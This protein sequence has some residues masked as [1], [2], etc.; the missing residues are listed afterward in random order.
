MSLFSSLRPLFISS[1][2]GPNQ[3]LQNWRERIL[4]AIATIGAISGLAV[5][6]ITVSTQFQRG[7]WLLIVIYS[8]AYLWMISIAIIR[9][10]PYII[11]ASSLILLVFLIGLTTTIDNATVGD[12]NV[13][14]VITPIFAAIF[15][16]GR[17]GF[18]TAVV[19]FGTWLLLG[20][21]F[22][23]GILEYPQKS[24]EEMVQPEN[25]G[26]WI[27]TGVT[28]FVVSLSVAAS[29]SAV[30]NNLNLTLQRSQE[31]TDDIEENRAQLQE[32]TNLL[33][34]RTSAL[35]NTTW[36]VSD[37][38]S[39]LKPDKLLQR[40]ALLIQ[41]T[42]DLNHVDIFLVDQN[43]ENAIL[44]ACSGKSKEIRPLGQK[45]PLT[46]GVIGTTIIYGQPQVFQEDDEALPQSLAFQEPSTR[47]FAVLPMRA[48]EKILGAIALQSTDIH[49]FEHE[50]LITFQILVDQIAILLENA[51]YFVER[52]SAIEAER[53]A[54]G[55][56]TQSAWMQIIQSRGAIG[57]HRDKSGLTPVSDLEI[58]PDKLDANT[59]SIPIKVRGQVIGSIDA[60]KSDEKGAWRTTETDL[61]NSLSDRL[62]SALDTARLYEDTQLLAE[63]ERLV[64]EAT[65]RMRE[66]LDIETVLKTAVQEIRAAMDLPEVTIRLTPETDT[67]DENSL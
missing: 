53:R 62:E 32:Q 19:C 63:Q 35:E 27:N 17:F 9:K 16:G 40:A 36:I 42:F 8:L 26:H 48:R 46:D 59:L 67:P 13:W 52:E 43:E 7:N 30:L 60:K 1:S 39:I 50:T 28:F 15:I 56:L 12:G 65:A 31:L 37:I 22:S 25:F 33:T 57:F 58:L 44:Q 66:T 5:Y 3:E 24:V 6:L 61:L 14:L 18:G 47:S 55:D 2:R 64:S 38:T 51:R 20:F 34:R 49:T 45:T 10:L 4:T 21:L 41:Q 11:R 29:A 54:Y 23:R